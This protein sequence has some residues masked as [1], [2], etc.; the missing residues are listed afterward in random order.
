MIFPLAGVNGL[1]GFTDAL[2]L[3]AAAKCVSTAY[4]VSKYPSQIPAQELNPMQGK[5]FSSSA[6]VNQVLG[7]RYRLKV[8]SLT[9]ET[10]TRLVIKVQ[11]RYKAHLRM[12]V[13]GAD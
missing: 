4:W 13:S 8:V 2:H 10:G 9:H 7:A 12:T 5:F 3:L 1:I 6:S 11:R